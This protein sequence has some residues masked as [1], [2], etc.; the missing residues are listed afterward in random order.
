M[1][2]LLLKAFVQED[3]GLLPWAE[4]SE[5]W[6]KI[7]KIWKFLR[8]RLKCVSK[9]ILVSWFHSLLKKIDIIFWRSN[10]NFSVIHVYRHITDKAYI[11]PSKYHEHKLLHIP[12]ETIGSKYDGTHSCPLCGRERF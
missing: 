12:L 8:K 4:F 6:L 10:L 1:Q 11:C 2:F 9:S 7:W 5:D 3:R